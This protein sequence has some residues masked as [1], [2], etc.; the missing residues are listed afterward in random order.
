MFYDRFEQLCISKGVRPGRACI[1]MGLSRSLAAKWKNS[2][3]KE[4]SADVLKK[5]S[6]Y[7]GI[8]ID[9]ILGDNPFNLSQTKAPALTKKDER[10]IAR[11]LEETL[12][13]LES[14]DAL[15]FDGE[16]LDEE[17][18][19]L[20]KVSLQNQYT[21]AKQIAKQKFTNNKNR[22]KSEK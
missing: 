10:D 13:L 22:Q 12:H 16:P 7:F 19:E 15:M 5:M 8:S 14:S 6:E 1:E 11:R 3:T 21:L 17:S 2:K 20:L 4:P 9:E 18:M